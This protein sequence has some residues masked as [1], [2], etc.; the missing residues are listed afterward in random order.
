MPTT[1]PPAT[2]TASVLSQRTGTP[3]PTIHHYRHLGLLPEPLQ[4]APNKFLYDERHAEALA[5]IRLLRE[6]HNLPLEDIREVLPELLSPG[7]GR[8]VNRDQWDSLV[9]A[10]L[11]R[12]GASVVSGRLV[13]AARDAFAKHGYAGANVADICTTAGIA[14]GSFYR[15]FDSKEAIF[16]A[17]ARSTV[18][19]VGEQLDMEADR[20]SERQAIERLQHLL[21]PMAPLLLEVALAELRLQPDLVGVVTAIAAGLAT[22]LGPRLS[23]RG[24]HSRTVARRV[25]DA[26]FMGLLR[27]ALGSAASST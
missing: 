19:A 17:A 25:V 24:D 8:V 5:A 14:K 3:V 12:T 15:Y 7:N 23:A 27:P 10:H 20:M 2:F 4:L 21:V 11:E 26:A 1:L 16:L 18:D 9:D 13:S 6:R 22:R